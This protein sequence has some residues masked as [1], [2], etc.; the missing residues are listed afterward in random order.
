M[1]ILSPAANGTVPTPVRFVASED[2]AAG[3][4]VSQ[5]DGTPLYKTAAPS[6]DAWVLLPQ[7]PQSVIVSALGGDGNPIA[8][9]PL[10]FD[11]AGVAMPVP[12]ADAQSYEVDT[13]TWTVELHDIGGR[14]QWG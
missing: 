5:T 9:E 8:S 12:P 11:V 4:V 3:W 6:L 13:A 1:Q 10:Q 2:G 14:F 7:T